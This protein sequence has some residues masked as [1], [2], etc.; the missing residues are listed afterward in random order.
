LGLDGLTPNAA[1][2]L[3]S[4]GH[5]ALVT[6]SDGYYTVN[7][8]GTVTQ[9]GN[10]SL[11]VT[12]PDAVG[13][14]EIISKSITGMLD[15]YHAISDNINASAISTANAAQAA[16]MLYDML[17]LSNALIRPSSITAAMQENTDLTAGQMAGIYMAAMRQLGSDIFPGDI[18]FSAES[19]DLVVH[20]DIYFRG[21]LVA[22]NAVYTPISFLRDRTLVGGD[23]N[24]WRGAGL[25]MVWA[26]NVPSLD[27]WDGQMF[28]NRI[29]ELSDGY[30]LDIHD[31]RVNGIQVHEVEL[32]VR[33]MQYLGLMEFGI[34]DTAPDP[35]FRTS[36][37]TMYLIA[38]VITWMGI[39]CYLAVRIGGAPGAVI[40]GVTLLVGGI[41]LLIITGILQSWI[42]ELKEIMFGW[43]PFW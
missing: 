10:V 9:T 16:W 12:W 24:D 39:I 15:A 19:L 2:V 34:P 27:E 35:V 37:E 23:D 36:N 17:E 13:N 31:M 8:G 40:I 42:D 25:A 14:T 32:T 41:Y 18:V 5:L 22:E 6:G 21:S 28:Y 4:N 7:H 1:I 11:T 38:L 29:I 26:V 33:S 3:F 43:W 30:T 20:G